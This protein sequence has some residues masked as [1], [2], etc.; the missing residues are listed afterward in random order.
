MLPSD[1]KYCGK[2]LRCWWGEQNSGRYKDWTMRK[3]HKTCWFK[4]QDWIKWQKKVGKWN[5]AR[6]RMS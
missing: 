2:A 6:E 5:Y 4:L 3:Y 1:C